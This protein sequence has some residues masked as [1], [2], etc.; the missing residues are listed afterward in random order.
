MKKFFV[1]LISISLFS[2]MP[3]IVTEAAPKEN[4]RCTTIGKLS[5]KLTCVSLDGKKFWYELTLAKGVKK[6]AKAETDCYRE[7]LITRGYDQSKKLVELI[8]KYP[9]SV[10]GSTPPIWFS[11]SPSKP[12]TQFSEIS[13]PK[14]IISQSES[15]TD[16]SSCR[17]RHLNP[18]GTSMVA[19]FPVVERRINLVKGLKAQIIGVDFPDRQA[20]GSVN[21]ASNQKYIDDTE[22]FWRSQSTN[23][24]KFEW[25]WK[26]DWIRMPQPIKNYDLGG[27]FLEGKFRDQPYWAIIRNIISMADSTVD[28]NGVNLIIIV[29]P[30]LMTF[31][32]VGTSLVHTQGAYTTSEGTIYNLMLAGG[33]SSIDSHWYQHEFGHALGLTDIRDTSNLS[34]QKSDGMYFDV[35]NNPVLQE[36]IVWHRFLLGFLTD[37]QIHCVTSTNSSTH[38]LVPVASQSNKLKGVVIPLSETEALIVESRR[39][40]GWDNVP[41]TQSVYGLSVNELMG[42]VVY[43]LDTSIPYGKTPIRVVKVLKNSQYT[44]IDGYK[45]S[46]IESGDFGDV[47]KVEKVS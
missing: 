37:S 22:K 5:G 16:L 17:I 45:I 31:D 44:Y 14:T 4:T 35:M 23:Q 27:A 26:K 38:W 9:T 42:A 41:S 15:F 30:N 6:Y 3:A 10:K 2:F 29:F 24:L 36:T 43:R 34:N 21:N 40:I 47:V 33:N 39:Q 46:N 19:G 8:C 25:K 12:S 7:N 20:I 28:F 18:H 11:T 32:D 13:E 1:F